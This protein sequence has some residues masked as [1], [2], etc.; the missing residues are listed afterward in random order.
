MGFQIGLKNPDPT[1]EV[2]VTG[3]G[4]ARRRALGINLQHR[5]CSLVGDFYFPVWEPFG[6]H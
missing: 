5:R 4:I 1:T 3:A 2:L 6:K